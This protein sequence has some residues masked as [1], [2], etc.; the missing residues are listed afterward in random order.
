MNKADTNTD[1]GASVGATFGR[2]GQ[3]EST[4]YANG[5][6]FLWNK[7]ESAARPGMM[8]SLFPEYKRVTAGSSGTV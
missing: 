3:G 5:T 4:T 6:P 7:E 8:I 2:L 1:V